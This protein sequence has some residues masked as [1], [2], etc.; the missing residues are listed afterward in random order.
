[1]ERKIGPFIKGLERTARI[2]G[3]ATAIASPGVAHADHD[4]ETRNVG[5]NK[6]LDYGYFHPMTGDQVWSYGIQLRNP[7]LAGAGIFET[8]RVGEVVLTGAGD[9]GVDVKIDPKFLADY[10]GSGA[11]VAAWFKTGPGDRVVLMDQGNGRNGPVF[12]VVADGGGFAGMLL[13]DS[14]AQM[15]IRVVRISG[16]SAPIQVIFGNLSQEDAAKPRHPSVIDAQEHLKFT[17]QVAEPVEFLPEGQVLRWDQTEGRGFFR[18]I[19]AAGEGYSKFVEFSINN[20]PHNPDGSP[21]YAFR[22]KGRVGEFF[23]LVRGANQ[24]RLDLR[25]NGPWVEDIRQHQAA[26]AIWIAGAQPKT[27]IQIHDAG[28]RV[29]AEAWVDDAGFGGVKLPTND[30]FIITLDIPFPGL[31]HDIQFQLGPARQA[32]LEK[33]STAR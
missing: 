20:V 7:L 18:P 5:I 21:K 2:A 6:A 30:Q 14:E 17:P 31:A 13:P 24:V 23:A 1:M 4:G 27:K 8:G 22:D 10:R 12:H 29:I 25:T 28:G 33:S 26:P 16:S 11:R 3:V 15:G 32:D 19:S 9:V